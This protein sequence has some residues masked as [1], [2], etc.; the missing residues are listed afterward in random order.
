MNINNSSGSLTLSPFT[1]MCGD[2][3]RTQIRNNS[4]ILTAVVAPRKIRVQSQQSLHSIHNL[5]NNSVTQLSCS[6]FDY[7]TLTSRSSVKNLLI[8]LGSTRPSV[9]KIS[10]EEQAAIL[11][12]AYVRRLLVMRKYEQID[13]DKTLQKMELIQDVVKRRGG[14]Y[15]IELYNSKNFDRY[16]LPGIKKDLEMLVEVCRN[17]D[18]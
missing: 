2:M 16:I 11:I 12:Q 6:E 14:D 5:R 18:V 15:P 17:K 9:T 4:I 1:V 3:K 8:S 10:K 13:R 7:K